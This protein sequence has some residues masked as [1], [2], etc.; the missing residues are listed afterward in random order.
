MDAVTHPAA[1]P[2]VSYYILPGDICKF[3]FFA[4]TVFFNLDYSRVKANPPRPYIKGW[5][6]KWPL[7]L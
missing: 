5:A 6:R 2:V 1:H 3:F 7:K 4:A